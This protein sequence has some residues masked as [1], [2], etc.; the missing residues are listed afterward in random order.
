[1]KSYFRNLCVCF[2]VLLGVAVS[3]GSAVADDWPQW[4]GPDRDGVW[5][6]K[7]IL[8]EIPESGLK[9]VWRSD[10]GS[11]YSGPS[12]SNGRVYVMDRK[13]T[14]P[15]GKKANQ[16]FFRGII[17]GT[18]RV[19]CLN[20]KDGTLIWDHEYNSQYQ[21][22]YPS[23]PRVTP[24]VDDGRVYSLGA[25]GNLFCLDAKTGKVKWSRNL[26]RDYEVKTP[27]WGFAAHPLIHDGKVICLVGGRTTVVAFDKKNGK[28]LWTSLKTREPGYCPPTLL[29]VGGRKQL[30]VWHPE[31]V[32]GVDPK[33]GKHLWSENFRIKAGLT[34]ALPR[35]YEN[36]VFVSS[37]YNGPMMLSF[38]DGKQK[39][40]VAWRGK[41]KNERH[42]DSLHS[43]MATPFIEGDHIYGVGSY[44]HLRCVNAKTGERVWETLEAA[45]KGEPTRWGNAFIVNNHDRFFLFNEAGELIAAELS[46]EGFVEHGRTKLIEP[47]NADPRRSVVWSHPSFA[48]G[49]IIVRND[50]EIIAYSLKVDDD[51]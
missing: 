31:S 46:P 43:L 47:D 40:N 38:E 42:T 41:G 51:S 37:F 34:I 28:E 18:E 33:N 35:K 11:G 48:N 25:E 16:N 12:V 44:G 14:K 49:N 39:P 22:S 26:K 19:V 9:Q 36:N 17:S 7:G 1:M 8:R 2:A 32:N 45:T 3:V 30:I 27:L 5:K 50:R 13:V 20:E 6:E 21:I 24:T 4:M 15:V 29:N 10:L 23:G